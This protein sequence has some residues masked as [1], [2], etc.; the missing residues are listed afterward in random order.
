MSKFYKSKKWRDDIKNK[1]IN[2]LK[3]LYPIFYK[4]L[5]EH[6]EKYCWVYYVYMGP[7][8]KEQN[9]LDF[10]KDY[11]IKKVDP[12]KK[13]KELK[14]EKQKI[15]KLK[16]ELIKKLK[17]D[18]F[19]LTIINLA[20]KVIWAKPHRKDLQ[21]KSYF[22]VE[23]LMKEFAKRLYI[24]LEQARSAPIEILE[25][26]LKGKLNLEK[27]NSIYKMHACLP[28]DNGTFS[29]LIGK[30]AE[31]FSK[32]QVRRTTT[33]K[34]YQKIK[35]LTGTSACPG[36][37]KGIVKIINLTEDMKKMNYGD[38]LVSTATTPNIVPAMK[39]AAAIITDEG[40]LTSHAAIVSRELNTPCIVGLRIAT[41][42][43]KDG[44]KVEVD[45]DKGV[46]RR[47]K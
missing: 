26:G 33:G 17:P 5:S 44:D 27:I 15:R 1:N 6:T 37:A 47:I 32:K 12:I 36:H 41:K 24:S 25:K 35:S 30:Q 21:S 28:N 29:L 8:F 11:L 38:I 40:G 42:I 31:D 14:V 4:K 45:A 43:F 23:K 34:S 20:G 22:H 7:A 19:N 46:V 9:F 16:Q 13:L 39:K 2:K 18:K 3:K 10:I